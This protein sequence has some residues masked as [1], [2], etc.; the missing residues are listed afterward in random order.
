MNGYLQ[1]A[2]A[3]P[4]GKQPPRIEWETG[5]TPV[6][7]LNLRSTVIAP[8]PARLWNHDSS[9]VKPV[10]WSLYR[11]CPPGS[12]LAFI[13]THIH[14]H[15]CT[16]NVKRCFDTAV[17]RQYLAVHDRVQSQDNLC[18]TCGEEGENEKYFSQF[19]C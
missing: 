14:T 10:H 5:R 12:I 4:P 15:I 8:A 16:C 11:L 6:P 19:T 3:L 9:I 7:A 2:V 1:V 17:S 13:H 18:G